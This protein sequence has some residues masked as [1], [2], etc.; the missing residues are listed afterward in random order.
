MGIS[1]SI[2]ATLKCRCYYVIKWVAHNLGTLFYWPLKWAFLAVI[3]GHCVCSAAL[4]LP[5]SR[6]NGLNLGALD[7]LFGLKEG[8]IKKWGKIFMSGRYFSSSWLGKK[9]SL[10]LRPNSQCMHADC[11]FF[12]TSIN[13]EIIPQHPSTS[14]KNEKTVTTLIKILFSLVTCVSDK[15][16]DFASSFLSAPTTYW[17]FSKACSNFNN[18]DGENAVRILLGFLNGS[19]NS[20]KCGPGNVYST[21][22]LIRCMFKS[23]ITLLANGANKCA[24]QTHVGL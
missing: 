15:L 2:Y 24:K 4:L 16:S 9:I 21:E 5:I 18:C 1:F 12:A 20:G 3:L 10:V 7:A 19:R 22:I 14:N 11:C 8:E 17:F 23:N 13:R 6:C